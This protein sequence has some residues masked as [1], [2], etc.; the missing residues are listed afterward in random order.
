VDFTTDSS[1]VQPDP[2]NRIIDFE[3][4]LRVSNLLPNALEGCGG[5]S[6][7]SMSTMAPAKIPE[8]T[9]AG[10]PC[11]GN[12][13]F[14]TNTFGTISGQGNISSFSPSPLDI[15]RLSHDDL[16]A[17]V[18]VAIKQQIGRGEYTNL[19]LL[20]KGSVELSDFCSGSILKISADGV[21]ETRPKECKDRVQSIEKWTDA[22]LIFAC[23][24]LSTHPDKVYELLH[25]MWT[26][27]ECAARQ[28]GM[29]WREYDEQFRLRQ[30]LQP[31]SWASINNDLWWR[32]V[33]AR[34]LEKTPA[35][36]VRYTCNQYNE[37]N[38]SWYN[39]R[40]AHACSECGLRHPVVDCP[41]KS[42]QDRPSKE[43]NNNFQ[44]GRGS[45]RG[46]MRGRGRGSARGTFNKQ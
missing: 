37:G 30:V 45:F 31:S 28:G 4:I 25:Y 15:Q 19:A 33:Q 46:S 10:P 21:I 18:P 43:G 23:I 13:H 44:R 24:Y 29:A 7:N 35:Q 16:A 6:L 42:G 26:I 40:F 17:H 34:P 32:C 41:S 3:E 36:K 22:F 1:L 20:L 39:C 8:R 5:S 27:R 12:S 11:A 14:P 2:G 38:C 9:P